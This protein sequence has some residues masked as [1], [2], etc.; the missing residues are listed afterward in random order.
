[1]FKRIIDFFRKKIVYVC[2]ICWKEVNW[3]CLECRKKITQNIDDKISAWINQAQEKLTIKFQIEK[4]DFSSIAPIERDKF[5]KFIHWYY[6]LKLQSAVAQNTPEL[7]NEFF[8]RANEIS[9][10]YSSISEV[11]NNEQ[12]YIKKIVDVASEN[13]EI[14]QDINDDILNKPESDLTKEELKKK[15]EYN[16][17]KSIL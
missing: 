9:V 10:L 14:Q 16:A 5:L 6:L 2:P 17:K 8:I 7:R 1:M 15:I 13:T 11:H 3:F 4:I 12:K